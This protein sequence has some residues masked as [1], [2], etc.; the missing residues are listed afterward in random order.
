MAAEIEQKLVALSDWAES[1]PYLGVLV[2]AAN[3]SLS[4][5]EKD[6]AAGVAYFTFLSMFPLMLGLISLG[7]YV[8]KSEDMQLRV[9][10]F[11]V[12]S[13]PVSA[14]FVTQ[15][16]DSLV[17]IRGAVGLTSA[18]VLIWSASKM[19]GALSR[20]INRALA[21]KR[22]FAIFLSPLRNFGL[23]LI[24]ATVIVLTLAVSP[25]IDLLSGLQLEYIGDR[26]NALLKSIAGPTSN[27]LATGLMIGVI[28]VLVPHH[29]LSFSNMVPGL[30]TATILI[31][32]G[33]A[34]FIWY[35]A[36]ASS[37]SAVYGSV[38]TIIVLLIWLYFA[39]RVVLYGAQ[40]ISVNMGNR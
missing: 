16:M 12:G 17:R 26:G 19:V 27:L 39:A 22:N 8:L 21:L 15:I 7:G 36:T 5:N 32:V 35:V 1:A 40:V 30:L 37:Y 14:D 11:I 38:S 4:Q 29:R 25:L 34:A 18:L 2:R 9:N 23:T 10:E 31:E 33:K 13:L 20:S 24:V 28:Y 6:M 3:R